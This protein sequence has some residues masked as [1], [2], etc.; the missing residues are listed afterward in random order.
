MAAVSV[1]VLVLGGRPAGAVV[2]GP[3]QGQ[4]RFETGTKAGGPFTATAD[5]TKTIVIPVRDRV[6]WQG[7]VSG[8]SGQRAING[9]V[10][11]ALPWPWGSVTVEKWGNDGRLASA[12]EN[13][14]IENYELPNLVPRGV[15][16]LVKGEHHDQGVSCS[17][18]VTVMVEGS[19][20]A[21]PLTIA[22]LALTAGSAALFA[23][24]GRARFVKIWVEHP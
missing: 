21:S 18:S 15:E 6:D 14:G 20:F 22:S 16:L 5:S 1:G 23:F 7:S 11:V 24:A 19:R 3:C 4:A 2:T 8:V 10:E 9:F 17:G 13:R 12:V